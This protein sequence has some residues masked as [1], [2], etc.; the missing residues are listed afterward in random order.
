MENDDPEEIRFN[1]ALL[2]I[3]ISDNNIDEKPGNYKIRRYDRIEIESYQI[4]DELGA[5]TNY[6]IVS[7][8]EILYKQK[9]EFKNKISNEKDKC[10][11]CQFEFYEDEIAQFEKDK[12]YENLLK[13]S[14]NVVLLEK[15]ADHFFHIEC[16]GNLIKGKTN[17]KCPNCS[18]IY[19]ILTG[20][21]P[22]GTFGAHVASSPKCS[23]FEKCNTIIIKYHF[24]NGPGYTGTS[25]TSYL[26][27]NKEGREVLALLKVAF[28]RKLTFTVGTSVT[29]GKKNTVV[30]NGIHHKT[31][32][33]GG[34]TCFGY[35]DNTYFN[36]VKEE[37]ASKGVTQESIDRDLESIAK[38]ILHD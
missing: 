32:T 22:D 29:T 19:G 37:L 17:F 6:F 25:R 16:I 35:P 18:R 24:P 31:S 30:W 3:K 34:P 21:M 8:M 12:N 9:Y 36:R 26:P 33:S 15:C 14:F 28:D 38:E 27:N 2:A 1:L 20:N 4:L 23:G 13:I 5:I 7:P 11:I 10:S